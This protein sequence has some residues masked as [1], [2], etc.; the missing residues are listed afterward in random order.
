M[1]R[2]YVHLSP[3]RRPAV[4]VGSRHTPH[5]VIILVRAQT[6]HTSG[7]QFYRPEDGLYLSEP[8][9][10]QFLD[11]PTTNGSRK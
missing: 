10:P 1:N 6:A 2:Q 7:I 3:D 4:N 9:P 8:I 5:P 11:I